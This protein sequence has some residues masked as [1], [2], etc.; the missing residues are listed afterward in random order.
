MNTELLI[1]CDDWE[2]RVAVLEEGSLAEIYFERE[3]KVIGSIYKGRVENVLPGMGACFV[4]I[5][6]G[7]N[8]FLYVDDIRR[9]PINIGETEI[10]DRRKGHTVNELLKV[11]DE[12]LV[13]IVKEPR[14]LKGAR[15]ST[16]ISLPGRYLVL[17]PTGRYSGV[18]SRIED[19]KERDRLKQVMRRVRPE[20]MATIVRTA[21][22]GVSEAELIADLGVQLRLWH[23][24]LESYKRSSAP[25][26]LHKDL[27]LVFK[28]VRDFM[29]SDVRQVIIDSKEQY[30][31]IRSTMSLLGPQYL[32]RLKLWEGP[33]DLFET[34]GIDEELQKLLKPKIMLPSGGYLI[35]EHTE[36]LTV[37]D[38]NTGKFTGGRNLEDTLVRTNIEAAAEIA[39][40]VRLRD[41][42]GIIVVDFIDMAHERSRQQV[43]DTLSEALKRDRTRSTIQAFSNLGL[44]EFTRKRVGKD[45]AG[46]LRSDCP[47]CGGLGDVMSSES[48][49]IALLRKIQQRG[50]NGS[51]GKKLDLVVDPS[52]ATQLVGWYREELEK[53]ERSTGVEVQLYVDAQRHRESITLENARRTPKPLQAGRELEVELLPVRL[54]DPGSGVAVYDGNIIEVKDAA[55]GTGSLAKV[56]VTAVDGALAKAELAEPLQTGQRRRRRG[57][58]RG[59]SA[60][61]TEAPIAPPTPQRMP[62]A[63]AAEESPARDRSRERDRDRDRDAERRPAA[64]PAAT[65]RHEA[66]PLAYGIDEEDE[67][68]FTLRGG[69]MAGGSVGA[70]A[71]GRA[72]TAEPKRREEGRGERRPRG[73]HGRGGGRSPQYPAPMVVGGEGDIDYE[74]DEDA[75]TVMPARGRTAQPPAARATAAPPAPVESSEDEDDGPRRRRRRRGRGRGG[76][77]ERPAGSDE[78][79]VYREDERDTVRP[80]ASDRGP[81][82]RDAATARGGRA[83]R[84]V[85]RERDERPDRGYRGRDERV[86]R[87]DRTRVERDVRPRDERDVRP[88]GERDIRPRGERDVRP[89]DERDGRHREERDDRHRG[90]RD[91]HHR[92]ERPRREPRNYGP[93]QQLYGRPMEIDEHREAP[94]RR[95]ARPRDERD[96]DDLDR[97]DAE[98]V[99]EREPRRGPREGRGDRDARGD[100]DT[101][102]ARVAGPRG[103]PLGDGG[104]ASGRETVREP[105]ADEEDGFGDQPV[106][107][108]RLP[109]PAPRPAAYDDE[110]ELDV[111]IE[112]NGPAVL[113]V[114]LVPGLEGGRSR[115]PQREP[116]DADRGA[117][118]GRRPRPDRDG[119]RDARPRRGGRDRGDRSSGEPRVPRP[120]KQLY[121]PP[122][123]TEEPPVEGA[124]KAL[125][126]ASRRTPRGPMMREPGAEP[127]PKGKVRQLYPPPEFGDEADAEEPST[128]STGSERAAG[129]IF[130]SGAEELDER[131]RL[132]RERA[133]ARLGGKPDERADDETTPSGGSIR[134]PFGGSFDEPFDDEGP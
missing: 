34:R 117:P 37:I 51:R 13:Q 96:R 130:V 43:I 113:D 88:R 76:A 27:N 93:I 66:A 120:V 121:P 127:P 109:R 97:R 7:R 91:E 36:A 8:A 15:V 26:L 44:L 42:G 2:N 116:D 101:R 102:D 9:D 95:D 23:G 3:E 79:D 71:A 104:R 122:G 78:R 39:R 48:L 10:T 45:L 52:V 105:R 77:D 25:A 133:E 40:Q 31:E 128:A 106:R 19:E 129:S 69:R 20:G 12:I 125:P 70:G 11:G 32:S 72:P 46:Q 59:K 33:G 126:F 112:P 74:D 89:R 87:D 6:L 115:R 14:G 131:R 98:R 5:G 62:A 94:P 119:D 28:A 82:R 103:R 29:T 67:E 81:V 100:R 64:R 50:Q 22:R 134:P 124:P 60:V 65:R 55:N 30:D 68:D 17:M 132:A 49:A 16:N 90:D 108:E 84:E 118:R 35:L 1:S 107:E 85:D 56:K 18:S 53:L 41:I 83:P 75:V 38:V 24:I 114:E 63:G 47:Y 58:G 80:V 99:S 111:V 54:P 92:E 21:A 123:T 86:E 110:D 61:E 73:G 4:N 57:R